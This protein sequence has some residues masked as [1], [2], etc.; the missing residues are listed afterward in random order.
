MAKATVENKGSKWAVAIIF[1]VWAVALIA[2]FLTYRGADVGQL[3]NLLGNLGGGPVFGFEGFRDSLFGGVIAVAIGISWFGLG[4]FASSFIK[5][6][7]GDGH[8]HLLEL[9]MKTAIGAAIWSL[10]WFFLGI[11]GAYSSISAVIALVVGMGFA[12]LIFTRVRTVR[13]ESRVPEKPS[14]FDKVLIGLITVPVLLALIA[15]LAPPTAKDTLLYHFALPKAFIAQGN[16]A[17][18][19]G[20]I[21]SFLAL[22]TE[23]HTVWAMLLGGFVSQRSGEAA[24]GATIFLFFPILLLA[25]F[26][27]SRELKIERSWSLLAVLIFA[28]VPTA[29]H[30]ASSGYADLGLALYVTLAIYALG[31]WW[32]SEENGWL[33]LIAIFLGAALSVKLTTLFVIAAFALVILLRV[34]KAKAESGNV[35]KIFVG[36]FAALIAAG[37]VAAD[38]KSVV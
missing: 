17:F 9:A 24:A 5:V 18:I 10:I 4:S 26:G 29:F 19:E 2:V 28:A 31:R 11:A 14:G 21:A 37:F 38:R 22:G 6:S 35:G 15:S 7:P 23:M 13:D 12:G 36:G 33:I 25:I 1:A 20:N 27:W 16:N 34:R 3:P 32:K 30:V 8:S